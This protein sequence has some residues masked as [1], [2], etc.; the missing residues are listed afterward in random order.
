MGGWQTVGWRCRCGR[1]C[2]WVLARRVD[3]GDKEVGVGEAVEGAGDHFLGVWGIGERVV[4][5]DTGESVDKLSAHAGVVEILCGLVQLVLEKG[6]EGSGG[7]V[8]VWKPCV[9]CCSGAL[10]SRL[11]IGVVSAC[12]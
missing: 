4:S 5:D 8:L 1:L 7:V 10:E 12:W 9:S 3:D 11:C 2:C 6:V